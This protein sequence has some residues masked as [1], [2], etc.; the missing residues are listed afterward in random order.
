MK[1][2]IIRMGLAVFALGLSFAVSGVPIYNNGLPDQ[3]SGT[4]M[5]EVLVAENFTIGAAA[6]ITNIRFWSIQDLASAY[7][8]NIYWAIYSNTGNQPGSILN[9]GVTSAVSGTA[10]GNSTSFGYAEF[11]FDISVVFQLAVGDY[12]LALHNGVLSNNSPSEMLWSTTAAAIGS[13]SL[14]LDP[15]NSTTPV[16][17]A[18]GNEQAFQLEGTPTTPS[19]PEPSTFVL[20]MGGLLATALLRRKSKKAV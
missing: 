1:V 11:F 8:G 16:W 14:Y 4:N 5:S 12:W 2:A 19:V 7:T 6:D 3:V 9:G 15:P 20:L 17:I 18:S 13:S 10:T